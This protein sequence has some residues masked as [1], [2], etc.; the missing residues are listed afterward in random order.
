MMP[1]RRFA[2][3]ISGASGAG[4]LLPLTHTTDGYRFRDIVSTR[5]LAVTNCD[6]FNEPLLYLFYGRPA[7]R[8]A[9]AKKATILS[10][11]SL[12]CF[13]LRTEALTRPRRLF[14][15]DTGAMHN[16]FY[17]AYLHPDM[18]LDNFE[19]E[20]DVE[21]ARKLVEIFYEDNAN[22][23]MGKCASGK[24]FPILEMEAHCYYSLI[25]TQAQTD[26]DDRKGSIEIQFDHNI[27]LDP[28]NV[29]AVVMPEPFWDD[30]EISDFVVNELRA[31][32]LSYDCFHAQPAEDTR[33]IMMEV[34][35]FLSK[36]SLL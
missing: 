21:E 11:F 35:R 28:S 30:T 32:A 15:F 6:V 14:P 16:G 31:D 24:T 3:L 18:S 4:T 25:G 8:S 13:V 22:Y 7:Y 17:S 1:L 5:E 26:T 36:K 2:A 20:C 23:F 10:A 33:A 12:V 29:L 19:L 34:R 27:A 9:S